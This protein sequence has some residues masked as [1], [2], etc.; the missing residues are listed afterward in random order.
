MEFFEGEP[1]AQQPE[2]PGPTTQAVWV[3]RAVAV[4]AGLLIFLLIVLGI[5]GCLESRKDRGI[6]NYANDANDLIKESTSDGDDFFALLKKPGNATPL[7]LKTQFN[8]YKVSAQQQLERAEKL[9]APDEL[10]QAND[11]LVATLRFR[12]QG[13]AEIA[14][15]I[16]SA[17]SSKKSSEASDRIAG[18]MQVFLASDV[19]YLRRFVPELKETLKDR[20][21][22]DIK[23][24]STRF[25]NDIT[26]LLPDTVADRLALVEGTKDATPGLHGVGLVK[27]TA[28][29]SGAELVEGQTTNIKVSSKLSFAVEIQNQGDNEETDVVVRVQIGGAKEIDVEKAV[30][31]VGQGETKSVTI[32]LS[33]KPDLGPNT[34]KVRV[35][36]VPG[37]KLTDNNKA[38][39]PVQFEQ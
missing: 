2:P 22:D 24:P 14:R 28:Q 35:E 29:P 7:D 32:P 8:Q 23:V 34:V 31:R 6:K 5:R 36:P 26:W 12:E 38:D 3:R 21:I 39:Y 19:L 10:K 25:L 18:E 15:M 4:G 30:R 13:L 9:D 17:L 20:G 33:A 1:T 37:E 27:A 11:W 16:R